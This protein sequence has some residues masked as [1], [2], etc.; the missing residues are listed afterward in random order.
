MY[1]STSEARG[2]TPCKSACATAHGACA[3]SAVDCAV[4]ERRRFRNAQALGYSTAGYSMNSLSAHGP[5]WHMHS[6]SALNNDTRGNVHEVRCTTW[7][8]TPSPPRTDLNESCI[9]R[10]ISNIGEGGRGGVV[11]H[12]ADI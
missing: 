1:K 8:Y 5:V 4:G 2:K 10:E 7:I 12:H 11:A 9:Y 6:R 3:R